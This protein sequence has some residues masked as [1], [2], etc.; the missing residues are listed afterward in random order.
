METTKEKV[1]YKGLPETHIARISWPAIFAGTIIML[2]TLMLL[3]LLGLGIGLGS[4]KPM[5][6][7]N[8]MQGLGT[9]TIIWWIISNLIAVCAGAYVA[10]NLTNVPYKLTGVYHGVLSWSLFTL[11]SF[12]VM[13]TAVGGIIS[14]TGGIISKGLSS[15]GGGVSELASSVGQGDTDRIK[16]MIQDALEKDKGQAGDTTRKEFDIDVAAVI[17]DVFFVNGKITEDVDRQDVEQSIARNSTLAQ[18]DVKRATDVIMSKYQEAR[19]QWAEV[20]PEVVK[21]AQQAAETASKAAIWFFVSLL[22]G[23]ITAA[24]GGKAGQPDVINVED[25]RTTL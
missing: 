24:I 1:Y 6:E 11:I 18:E 9:G 14:G 8:P 2:I 5:E 15:M 10:A 17:Q 12:W 21:G 7:S 23:V 19:Q 3:S 13:T 22:L 16:Q 4:I 20:K 25:R